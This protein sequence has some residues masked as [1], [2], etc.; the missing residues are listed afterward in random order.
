MTACRG[1]RR[2]SSAIRVDDLRRAIADGALFLDY[3]PRIDMRDG[4]MLG[5]EA[6][7]RWRHPELGIVAPAHFIGLAEQSG[8]IL[9]L[10]A[11]VLKEACRQAKAWQDAGLPE[12]I[13]AVNVSPHQLCHR[14]FVPEV[15]RALTESGLDGRFLELEL[16]ESAVMSD[17]AAAL[18]A[19]RA[20]RALGVALSIDDFGTGYANLAMLRLLPVERIKIDRSF[21]ESLPSDPATKAIAGAVF[22]LARALKLGV[23]A[24]GVETEA[25][26]RYLTEQGCDEAQGF[27]FA[28]P[29]TPAE[30]EARLVK[31]G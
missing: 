4:R 31:Q 29:G 25:Q 5:V 16:T 14:D 28:R 3:Q 19:M 24:E 21:V 6:L 18:A 1:V 7:V 10:G 15:R 9:P 11:L 26:H 27:L 22:G 2:R 17:I 13:M 23:V 30:I 12:I 20:V 8:L